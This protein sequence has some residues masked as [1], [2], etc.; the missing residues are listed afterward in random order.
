ML[1]EIG[2]IDFAAD[3]LGNSTVLESFI[4]EL[5]EIS[6]CTIIVGFCID[7]V[8]ADMSFRV[9]VTKFSADV[10]SGSAV[11]VLIVSASSVL[12]IILE[13]ITAV[14]GN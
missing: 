8:R 12:T 14:E 2:R 1:L 11:E 4:A 3:V 6:V 10:L 9:L 13:V 5:L 7:D